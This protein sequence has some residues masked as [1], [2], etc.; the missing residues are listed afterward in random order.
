MDFKTGAGLGYAFI[1][2]VSAG[3]AVRFWDVFQGFRDWGVP[4][5]RIADVGWAAPHQGLEAHIERYRSS[6][7]MS[8][9]TPD[10]Y[11]PILLHD[12]VRVPFPVPV[13]PIRAMQPRLRRH[14]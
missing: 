12:G 5:S 3:D 10:E 7:I 9:E 1:N 6:S 11:K 13:K 8:V 14:R 2:L 4:S